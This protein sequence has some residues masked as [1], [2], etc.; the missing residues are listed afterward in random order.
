MLGAP[1][2]P[3]AV[4]DDL[5]VQ[6]ALDAF[7]E[8]GLGSRVA[9]RFQKRIVRRLGDVSKKLENDESSQETSVMQ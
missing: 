3:L 5:T 1:G 6:D 4:D 9:I 2:R 7:V 8:C